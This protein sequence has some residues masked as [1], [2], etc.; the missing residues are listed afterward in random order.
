MPKE[1]ADRWTVKERA[2]GCHAKLL[3]NHEQPLRVLL[4]GFRKR[5]RPDK[6]HLRGTPT[7]I[8]Q[9][10]QEGNLQVGNG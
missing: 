7:Q 9:K 1:Q 8:L 6:R 3:R 5:A 10:L 2:S 4:S